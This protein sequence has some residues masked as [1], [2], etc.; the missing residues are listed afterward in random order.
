MILID[1]FTLQFHQ[2]P[3]LGQTKYAILSHTWGIDEVNYREFCNPEKARSKSS[4]EKIAKTCQLAAS[5][6]LQYVWIDTCCIDKSSSAELTEAINSM[7]QWYK[8]AEVCFAYIS[9]L[10]PNNGGPALDWLNSGHYR[11]FTRGW[12]LQ[13]LVAADKIEFYDADWGYRG[14]KATLM[15]QLHRVTVIDEQVLTDSNIL[16]EIPVARKMS[17]ASSRHTTRTEDMAYCLLGLF[18]I[19]MPMIY[20][21]GDRAFIRLQEEIAK[22]TNDLSLFAWT[23]KEENDSEGFRGMF[24]RSP[25]EFADC[26]NI[27][28]WADFLAPRP[29]FVIT[30]HGVR[31]E[32]SLGLAENKRFV[33]DLGCCGDAIRGE[34]LGIYLH[35]TGSKFV[36]QHPDK[37]YYTRDPRLWVGR[38]STVYIQKRLSPEEKQRIRL[39]LASRIYIRFSA[40][41]LGDYILRDMTTYP[42]ALWNPQGEYFLTMESVTSQAATPSTIYPRFIGFRG[43]DVRH[44]GAGH[45]CS[46]LVVCGIFE[47]LHGSDRPCA[48]IYTD[49]EPSTKGV[50]EA[51]AANKGETNGVLLSQIRDFLISKHSPDGSTLCWND[52]SNREVQIAQ[53]IIRLDIRLTRGFSISVGDSGGC[54]DLSDIERMDMNN[55]GQDIAFLPADYSGERQYVVSILIGQNVRGRRSI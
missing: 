50:F 32:T 45:I 10:S 42:G 40:R 6:G 55:Q 33:L 30:N 3:D 53:M 29:E 39:E 28:R 44:R 41:Q 38:K 52:V 19:S 34:R 49:T 47:D 22:E 54:G 18:D 4:Y 14:D 48:V 1:V 17:W 9:D 25:A 24:A 46:C 15:R 8:D 21:E 23:S 20:G 35:Q 12:T 16:A 26:R 27:V 11:W 2:V 13:E 5:R 31:L 51:I 43:F 36:R 7:F 37:L